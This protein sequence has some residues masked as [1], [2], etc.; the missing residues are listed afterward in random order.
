MKT[1]P[2]H[3]AAVSVIAAGWLTTSKHGMNSTADHV[4]VMGCPASCLSIHFALQGKDWNGQVKF[5]N[6]GF[7]GRPQY[8][9]RDAEAEL[10]GWMVLMVPDHAMRA[11]WSCLVAQHLLM[12]VECILGAV[13]QQEHYCTT[14]TWCGRTKSAWGCLC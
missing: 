5:G 8:S 3:A 14:K 1:L 2:A 6:G 9:H 13:P 10:Q 12:A 11:A 4:S 7:Y